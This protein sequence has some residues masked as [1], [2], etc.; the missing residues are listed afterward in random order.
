MEVLFAGLSTMLTIIGVAAVLFAA[1]LSVC[2]IFF[3]IGGFANGDFGYGLGMFL[4]GLG[5]LF[6][7]CVIGAAIAHFWRFGW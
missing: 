4:V 3:A 6:V 2:S 5:M 1:F 7:S